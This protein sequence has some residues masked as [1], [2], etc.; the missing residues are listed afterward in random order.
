MEKGIEELYK[1]RKNFSVIGLTGRKGAG[2]SEVANILGNKNIPSVE[3]RKPNKVYTQI[4][5]QEEE[6]YNLP[7]NFF[8][9]YKICYHYSKK[10]WHQYKTIR[11][12][13]VI[14]LHLIFYK[15]EEIIAEITDKEHF[16]ENNALVGDIRELLE[17]TELLSTIKNQ[18]TK[19][20]ELLR[21]KDE[22]LE[23]YGKLYFGEKNFEGFANSF[24]KILDK[25][26]IFK[27]NLLLHRL[28]NNLRGAGS[29]IS[30]KPRYSNCKNLDHIYTLSETINR[31]IKAWKKINKNE[32]HVVID[33]LKNSLEIMFFKER[34]SG[35]YMVSVNSDYR[36]ENLEEKYS[37]IRKK[38]EKD[39]L[40]ELTDNLFE[41]DETEYKCNDFKSGK[42]WAPDVG[43]CIQKCDI[44]LINNKYSQ[45]NDNK[46]DS[47]DIN[48]KDFNEKVFFT[49]GEQ[50]IKITSLISQPG[51][52][53]PSSRER[54]MQMAYN[55]KYNSGCLSRQV[56]AII[57]DKYYSVK[58]IGWNDVAKGQVP[59]K[60]RD[61]K[62][63]FHNNG[64]EKDEQAFS[65]F[66]L[67]Q[68]E[69]DKKACGF[70][71]KLRDTYD[72]S[73]K[74]I[75]GK[76][77]PYCFKDVFNAYEA[78]ENQ[79]HTRSLHAEENAMLQISKYGGQG[80]D[81]GKLFTTA[82][83]CELCSKKAYQLGIETIYYIDPYPG[84]SERHIL[85]GANKKHTPKMQLFFGAI[86]QA[87]HKLYEP[88]MSYK[89]ELYIETGFKPELNYKNLLKSLV[90]QIEVEKEYKDKL[91]KL[92]E[93][94]KIDKNNIE[95]MLKDAINENGKKDRN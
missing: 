16:G 90:E 92:I 9:K 61:I 76:P 28:A 17:N 35:F 93:H 5:K 40:K 12:R 43:N 65:P 33:S 55:A 52:I 39:K 58:S 68:Y 49:L 57:T 91:K 67:K 62:G 73:N 3:V 78:K 56:G 6:N 15:N 48:S 79:V 66:E 63:I 10:N 69:N 71:E 72:N 75:L 22:D 74:E 23:T 31:L 26:D 25:Y 14:L 30:S 34:Y 80:L 4:L 29:P 82:S 59:C 38:D 83:P 89:D 24:Y 95:K 51:L 11:Y 77:F 45:K 44:H 70:Y 86:G 46:K 18:F 81:K 85:E 42:F 41:L 94:E 2:C 53:T 60:L 37:F 88:F 47:I 20:D 50:L 7:L 36:R 54:C 84:I 87:F 27:R 1:L 21:I 64:D 8:R 19:Q 32:T 13:D